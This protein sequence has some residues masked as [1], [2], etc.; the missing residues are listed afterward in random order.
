METP[1]DKGAESMFKVI[2]NEN[3]PNPGRKIDIQIYDAQRTPN[4]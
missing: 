3:F 2:M 4:R 1:E